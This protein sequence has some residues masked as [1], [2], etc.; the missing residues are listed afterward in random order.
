M[1][2]KKCE[3]HV[4]SV[5]FLGFTLERGQFQTDP[6]KVKEVVEWPAPE[7]CKQLQRFLGF[8]NFYRRFIKN[9][10]LI[11]APLSQLTSHLRVFKCT[12]EADTAFGESKHL[13]SLA[14][15][16]CHPDSTGQL[17]LEV[18]FSDTGAGAVLS[19]RAQADNKGHPCAFFPRHLS[20]CRKKNMM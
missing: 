1:A 5:S 18:D 17:I 6:G 12:P 4:S 16:S 13:F 11:A 14:S 15:I 19:Q 9:Y 7:N 3:F 10:S 20:P 8:A 2:G